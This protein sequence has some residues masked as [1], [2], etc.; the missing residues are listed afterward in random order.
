MRSHRPLVGAHEPRSGP[1]D[2]SRQGPEVSRKE[3]QDDPLQGSPT[4]SLSVGDR[5]VA[6]FQDVGGELVSTDLSKEQED[7]LLEVFAEPRPG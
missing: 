5:A 4:S 1:N 7:H 6:A 2:R 3:G